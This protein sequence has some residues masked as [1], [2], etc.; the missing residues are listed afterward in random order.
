MAFQYRFQISFFSKAVWILAGI[1]LSLQLLG[2]SQAPPM[3]ADMSAS[4][5]STV[6]TLMPS[7]YQ[8]AP[9]SS[10]NIT[11]SGGSGVYSTV[12]ASA[13]SITQSS[14]NLF[15][16]T[17]PSTIG[18]G[19]TVSITAT[20]SLGS[21]GMTSVS[22]ANVSSSSVGGAVTISLSPLNPSVA[23][24]S[25]TT[26]TA[27][28]GNGN[29][30]WQVVG[31]GSLSSTSGTSVVFTAPSTAASVTIYV[32]DSNGNVTSTSVSVSAAAPAG[33]LTYIGQLAAAQYGIPYCGTEAPGSCSNIGSTCFIF[34]GSYT[35]SNSGNTMYNIF[36][37]H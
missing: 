12:N 33:T 35:D 32:Y 29:Y 14:A 15:V 24:N 10:I 19:Q 31:G 5:L 36:A 13:G 16:Y 1:Q 28:G 6:L 3:A 27:L 37:C 25:Q 22:I 18:L 20:D 26:F 8:V 7:A 9:G 21:S 30:T 23:G 2:C 11:I 34:A 17:A 4:S